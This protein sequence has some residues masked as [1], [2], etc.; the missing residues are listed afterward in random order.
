VARRVLGTAF[1]G[2]AML[3]GC[4]GP[5]G[6]NP[7]VDVDTTM[8]HIQIEL[9]QNKSPGTVKNFLQYVD[10]KFYDGTIFHRVMPDFMIQG[11][12]FL[13]GMKKEKGTRDPIKNES[14]NG[15]SNERGTV[16][17]ARTNDPD[18][19]TAQFFINLKDN[20]FLDRSGAPDGVGYCVFGKVTSGMDVVDKIAEVETADRGPH[21]HVPVEDV[22]IKAIR[23]VQTK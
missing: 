17:M 9:Y 14:S 10:D 6:P 21:E 20:T 15:V 4:G 19:A 8:G 12:G 1:L 23:R 2:L 13:P 18:S 5:S 16:A 7:V 11:G 3:A 22:V